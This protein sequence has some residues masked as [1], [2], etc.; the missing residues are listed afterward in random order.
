[1]RQV[2]AVEGSSEASCAPAG[3]RRRD[4][5]A[6]RIDVVLTDEDL[7]PSTETSAMLDERSAARSAQR[8][9]RARSKEH[10]TSASPWLPTT[11]SRTTSLTAG[12]MPEPAIR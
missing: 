3:G 8:M 10:V 9:P 2:A 5:V 4:E 11:L 6:S 1:M 12:P 7:F